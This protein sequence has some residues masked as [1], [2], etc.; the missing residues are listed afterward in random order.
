MTLGFVKFL[1]PCLKNTY[2]DLT[3]SDSEAGQYFKTVHL[4]AIHI[5]LVVHYCHQRS[6]PSVS[7]GLPE[8]IRFKRAFRGHLFLLRNSQTGETS[9]SLVTKFSYRVNCVQ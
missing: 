7:C 9:L 5:V 2:I 8:Y 4:M 6:M 1:L 3:E